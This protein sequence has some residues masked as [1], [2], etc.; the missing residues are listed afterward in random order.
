M[1]RILKRI[2]LFSF[3]LAVIAGGVAF[4]YF[5]QSDFSE[6]DI[7]VELIGPDEVEVGEKV[8]Y[9]IRYKNN[10]NIRLEDTSI[11]FEY[12]ETAV[13]VQEDEEAVTEEQETFR[14]TEEI[15]NVN[16]GEE[17]VLN[18]E[19]LIFGKKGDEVKASTWFNYRPQNLTANYEIKRTKTGIITDVPV[20]FEFDM[21]DQVEA[22]EE[23]PFRIRYY[24][25]LERAI[26]DLGIKINYPSDFKFV[27]STPNGV[28]DNEWQREVLNSKE[29][30][31]IEVFGKLDGEAGD[32]KGFEAQLGVWKFDRFIPL[33]TIEED[34]LIPQ[35]NL[36]VDILVND[37]TSH[38]A[39]PGE[40]LLYEIYFKNIGDK[41]LE[42]LFL[43]VDLDK[44]VMDM[45]AV[46]PMGARFQEDAGSLIW[47]H[48][49]F[50][51]LR[52]L[53]PGE[54]RKVSFWSKVKKKNLP[55]NPEALVIANLGKTIQE[56]RTKINTKISVD[57]T[58]SKEPIVSSIGPFPFRLNEES[59]YL[60]SWSVGSL[61]ND[62]KDVAVKSKLPEGATIKKSQVPEN[63]GL[64]FDKDSGEV[65]WNIK[66][67][68]GGAGVSHEPPIAYFQ[69]EF[70][71]KASVSS[72]MELIS[73]PKIIGTDSWTNK[74]VEAEGSKLIYQDLL[75]F[76]GVSSTDNI[77]ELELTTK[78]D[79]ENNE[80]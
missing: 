45:S 22:E 20:N 25:N 77:K 51:K 15:G 75:D 57:Q 23:F 67:I 11:I 8:E 39:D 49:S 65:I 1:K 44:S 29:G 35:P 17:K 28:E 74:S 61:Y 19:A 31:I 6:S 59:S 36:F 46:E 41:T 64:E 10:S 16:P 52:R 80:E 53:R 40:D 3:L 42:D 26:T 78:E 14:R 56:K 4:F 12:P 71:P 55:Q 32:I 73:A 30:G 66:K 79:K 47:S 58:F 54:E 2:A 38:V 68:E 13:P 9:K 21:P 37:S 5:Q 50:T 70:T 72:D 76:Y 33:S 48:S 27:R 63:S 62:I 43:T 7:K 60:V 34:V 69:V 18:F 24:S